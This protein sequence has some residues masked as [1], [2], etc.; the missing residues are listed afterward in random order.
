MKVFRDGVPL[1]IGTWMSSDK[2]LTFP[3]VLSRKRARAKS[4][5]RIK[6]LEV[7]RQTAWG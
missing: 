5:N 7:K 1:R 6:G 4:F 2:E 3:M